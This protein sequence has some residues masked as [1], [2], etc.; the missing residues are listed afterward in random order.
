VS[1]TETET[2]TTETAPS[3]A[4]LD[5]KV[6]ALDGKIDKIIDMFSGKEGQA[7]AAAQQRTEDRLDRPATVAEE[8]R[9]QLADA[10][11]AEAADAEKRGSADRLAALEA[12]VTGMTEQTP[13][14]PV[15]RVEK[16]LGWR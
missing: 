15:R 16:F 9:Q 5:A 8:I 12:K 3:N 13:E 14:A 2:E 7:R 6:T 1:E 11:A 4:E 10:K